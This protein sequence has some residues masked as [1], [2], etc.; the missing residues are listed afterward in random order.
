M[1]TFLKDEGVSKIAY[2]SDQEPAIVALIETAL[3]NCGKA[4]TVADAAPEHSAVG[5]SAS[6][7][8]AESAVKQFED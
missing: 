7:G 2:R 1:E 3:R 8:V 5:E 4:G 6:N